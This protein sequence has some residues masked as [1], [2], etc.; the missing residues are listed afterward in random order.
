MMTT[1]H[2]SLTP[3][4]NNCR[5][6]RETDDNIENGNDN[7]P[8]TFVA[9]LAITE[10]NNA[11]ST[12]LTPSRSNYDYRMLEIHPQAFFSGVE[13][14][15]PIILDS[16]ASLCITHD[17]ADFIGTMERST[18][19]RQ[20]GGLAQGLLIVGKGLVEWSFMTDAG[21]I[22]P[23]KLEAFL[24]PDAGQRLLSP[25]A[26]FQQGRYMGYFK[27]DIGKGYLF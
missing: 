25:Q 14:P 22:L 21:N 19:P 15:L 8:S 9:N 7:L 11:S 16:R 6:P 24:V 13:N 2:T 1:D 10:V 3:R 26:L 17:A 12:A 20:L 27:L 23:I 18:I 4:R 5:R